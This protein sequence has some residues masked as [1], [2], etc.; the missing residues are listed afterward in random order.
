M[1]ARLTQ[2]ARF[3]QLKNFPAA[4]EI[5]RQLLRVEPKNVDALL[6]LGLLENETGRNEESVQTLRAAL[7]IQPHRAEVRQTLIAPLLSLGR[8]PE[9]VVEARELVRLRPLVADMHHAAARLL[10]Q[11]GDATLALAYAKRATELN[12]KSATMFVTLGRVYQQLKMN[13]QAMIAVRRLL[14]LIGDVPMPLSTRQFCGKRRDSLM[15][16]LRCTKQV[17]RS[18]RVMWRL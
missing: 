9:A 12:R 10:L 2:A 17:W 1:D 14:L 4:E 16:R 13:D 8:L 3:Q 5:Y 18:S 7:K 6:L 11:S 15:T